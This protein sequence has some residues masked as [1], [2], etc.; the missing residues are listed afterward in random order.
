MTVVETDRIDMAD[1]NAER[2]AFGQP[3]DLTNT[4]L[5]ITLSTDK[6]PRD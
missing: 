6:F 3:V 2:V 5:G 4:P 1:D